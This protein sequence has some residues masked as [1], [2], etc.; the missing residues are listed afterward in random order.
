[1]IKNH[2]LP[3]V[4]ASNLTTKSEYVCWIDIMGTRNIMSESL[5]KATNFI[6]RFHAC[7]LRAITDQKNVKY[8]P[9]MDGVFITSPDAQTIQKV[10]NV[11][12]SNVANIFLAQ[13]RNIHRFIIKGSLAYGIVYHGHMITNDICQE[14]A[15]D[16]DYKKTILLGMPM[17]QSISMEK[18]APPF[19]IYIHESAR[20][21]QI[22]QGK[23][24]KWT[25]P[26]IDF[27]KLQ[28]K[29]EKYFDWCSDY[30]EYLEMDTQKIDK[31]KKLVKEYFSKRESKDNE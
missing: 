21:Y 5:Q 16:E 26:N 24:Y 20:K 23:Y 12:F 8:Y 3:E 18:T 19:G 1:M 7:V 17:I 27:V 29:V 15:Q 10:I 14:I 11:I 6:L 4:N 25:D 13:E 28:D 31:Y 2:N 30:S 9:L 22:L